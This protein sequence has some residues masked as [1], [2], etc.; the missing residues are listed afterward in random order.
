MPYRDRKIAY[1]HFWQ[2]IAAETVPIFRLSE[3]ML[4]IDTANNVRYN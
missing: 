1:N 4:V 3:H 2:K